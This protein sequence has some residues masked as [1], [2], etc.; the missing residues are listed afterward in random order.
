MARTLLAL[1]LPLPM[2]FACAGGPDDGPSPYDDDYP[3][4]GYDPLFQGAPNNDELPEEGKADAVYPAKFTDLLA[5]QSS[6]KSQGSRGVC[7][8]F[9]TVALMEHLYL[10]EGS[11]P[12]PDFSEQYLQ[13]SAKNEANSSG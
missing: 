6:V 1:L 11:L 10:K 8:I 4:S 12:D 7:S 3:V 9:A 5:T 2:L 13:W